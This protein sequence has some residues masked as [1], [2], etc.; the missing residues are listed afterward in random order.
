MTIKIH[1]RDGILYIQNSDL[2]IEDQE[3]FVHLNALF[4]KR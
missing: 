1:K 3:L 2:T 4:N